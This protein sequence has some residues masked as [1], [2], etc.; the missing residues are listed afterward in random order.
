M[1]FAVEGMTSPIIGTCKGGFYWHEM[2][3]NVAV[4][5]ASGV[6]A[7]SFIRD[8]IIFWFGISK[9][10]LSDNGTPFFNMHMRWLLDDYA[11]DL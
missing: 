1:I 3:K 5:R 9:H 10:L 8:N 7:A 6:T 11:N 4:K 2:V